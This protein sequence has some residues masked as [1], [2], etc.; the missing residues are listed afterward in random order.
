MIV[1]C[2]ANHGLRPSLPRY[3]VMCKDIAFILSPCSSKLESRFG[4]I[5][6]HSLDKM[7]SR[8]RDIQIWWTNFWR[9]FWWIDEWLKVNYYKAQN[10][11][12]DF[13]SSYT[14]AINQYIF[15][16]HNFPKQTWQ[17]IRWKETMEKECKV[18][19]VKIR[20]RISPNMLPS[21][22]GCWVTSHIVR[23][24]QACPSIPNLGYK[25]NLY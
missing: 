14:V 4:K 7:M 8:F 18:P 24:T 17:R 21:C 9:L 1:I 23:S 12:W 15:T 11:Y 3:D 25:N 10:A 22:M 6:I 20:F 5:K 19:Y 13:Y 2:K 16:R